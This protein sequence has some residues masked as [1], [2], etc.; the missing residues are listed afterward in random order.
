MREIER[1]VSS[2]GAT[3]IQ[4][5]TSVRGIALDDPRFQP[6]FATMAELDLPIWL[7]PIRPA[8]VADYADEQR[9]RYDIW[10]AFGWPYETSVAMAR[11]VFS[12][13]FDRHPDLKIITHHCGAMIPFCEGRIGGGLDQLGTRSDDAQDLAAKER[14]SGRPVDHFR[15]FYGDTALFGAPGGLECGVRF[16]GAER[17]LFG[18]DMPFDSGGGAGFVD[19]IAAIEQGRFTETERQLIFEGNARR[20]L[21]LHEGATT[22]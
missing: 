15:R 11:L 2:L 1:A 12:G 16:F 21:R 20:M 7:H 19:T 4:V 13:L 9:S 3:G 22:S 8:S 6:L 14:L 17:V 5:F 18:T 10:W